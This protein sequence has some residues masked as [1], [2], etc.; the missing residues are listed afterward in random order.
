MIKMDKNPK[1]I[2]KICTPAPRRHGVF[3]IYFSVITVLMKRKALYTTTNTQ[4]YLINFYF[5]YR[6][7]E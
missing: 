2:L 6:F 4:F 7:S 5:C 3:E 1:Q